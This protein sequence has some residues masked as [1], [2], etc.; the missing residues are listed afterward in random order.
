[1]IRSA[2]LS[3]EP[4]ASRLG[5]SV[6]LGLAFVMIAFVGAFG[7]S[8]GAALADNEIITSEPA[9]GAALTTSPSEI[10]FNFT[11]EVGELR[12]VSV[13]CNTEP[14]LV[15]RPTLS[16]NARTMTVEIPAPGL[17]QGL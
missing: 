4:V 5:R 12:V 14:Y 9:D 3:S 16:G 2:N 11:E 10:V 8:P 6:R 7:L 13:E 1:M 15:P 17:P